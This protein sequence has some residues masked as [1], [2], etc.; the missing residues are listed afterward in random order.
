MNSGNL[1]NEVRWT[2][3]PALGALLLWR[4]VCGFEEANPIRAHTPVPLLFLVLPILLH[5][6]TS[7]FV[8]STQRASG[9]RQYVAKFGDAKNSKQDLLLAIHDRALILRELTRE[10]LRVALAT[11]LLHLTVEGKVFPGSTTPPRTGVAATVRNLLSAAEKLGH[12]CGQLTL[13]E[14]ATALRVRF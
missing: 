7:E 4:F 5:Q 12:W 11:R 9:L 14:V 2:Q 3:N 13:H 1:A 8:T 6:P 10:S